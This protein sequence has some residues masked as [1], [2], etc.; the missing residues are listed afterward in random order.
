MSIRDN[1]E[2]VR[3]RIARACLRVGRDPGEVRLVAVTKTVQVERIK[4]ALECGQRLFGEN[5]VQEALPKIRELGP[6][7]H[8]HFIGHLQSNK[9]RQVVGKFQMIQTLDRASLAREL[10][11]RAGTGTPLEVLIQV[12]VAGEKSKSGVA[13]EAL[14]GLLEQVADLKGLRICGLMTIPPFSEDPEQARS[15]FC[16]LRELR[17][18]Y[19]VQLSPPHFLD[20]L[21]MGMTGDL[22]VA[23]EEGATIVRVGTAIF[24]ARVS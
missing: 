16:R 7:P 3:E 21:S 2:R 15:Y 18:R 13:G 4:E 1:L 17:E 19:R 12:N 20:E 6:G 8:W 9:A 5:Y 11:K 23:V 14:E 10:D 24:G 22:E